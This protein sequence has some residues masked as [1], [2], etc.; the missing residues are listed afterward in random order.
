MLLNLVPDDSPSDGKF[1]IKNDM[2]LYNI[3][4][5]LEILDGN[6][7]CDFMLYNPQSI[8]TAIQ[9]FE[10]TS[11][12]KES[13][14]KSFVGNDLERLQIL[15]EDNY[16]QS[17]NEISH[18][19][20]LKHPILRCFEL[21]TVQTTTI[22]ILVDMVL[23]QE[24]SLHNH[25]ILQGLMVPMLEMEDTSEAYAKFF[26]DEEEPT[27]TKF[28][29]IL[30]DPSL[31][32]FQ[33]KKVRLLDLDPSVLSSQSDNRS[34]IVKCINERVGREK[35]SSRKN[36]IKNMVLDTRHVRTYKRFNEYF[37]G[38]PI[39]EQWLCDFEFIDLMLKLNT[40]Y[41][42]NIEE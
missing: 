11:A 33:E 21:L 12:T 42:S 39:S 16:Y 19:F 40:V 13:L 5:P 20:S 41:P 35:K 23:E 34:M 27:T 7:L 36:K 28:S 22:E 29:W 3:F 10:V 30:Q 18:D 26:A 9:S 32:E 24:R 4:Q 37:T 6:C 17:T 25:F 38:E 14:I 1:F 8:R 31:P 15:K 2:S